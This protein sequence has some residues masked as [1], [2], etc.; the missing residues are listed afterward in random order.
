[1]LTKKMI[2][3]NILGCILNTV[4]PEQKLQIKRKADNTLLNELFLEGKYWLDNQFKEKT[5]EQGSKFKEGVKF[6]TRLG[7]YYLLCDGKNI[8][9][10]ECDMTF[11]CSVT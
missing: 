1:M 7:T 4:S 6:F 8:S 5:L 11:K 3:E 9:L 10:Y 2:N